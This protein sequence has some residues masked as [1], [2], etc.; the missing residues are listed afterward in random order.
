MSVRANSCFQEEW[1]HYKHGTK[2]FGLNAKVSR[3]SSLRFA[4]AKLIAAY[5]ALVERKST[6]QEKISAE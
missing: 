5:L 2:L 3:I 6:H 4:L 1:E